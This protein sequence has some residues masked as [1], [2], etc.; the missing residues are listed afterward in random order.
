MVKADRSKNKP[1]KHGVLVIHGGGL[2][3][4]Q[5]NLVGD[6]LSTIAN[7]LIDHFNNDPFLGVEHR[8]A[9]KAKARSDRQLQELD[10]DIFRKDGKRER[11]EHQVM[12]REVLW[13]PPMPKMP[14]STYLSLIW[15]W[16]FA[17]QS[18]N[19]RKAELEKRDQRARGWRCAALKGQ[20]VRPD[21]VYPADWDSDGLE[22]MEQDLKKD[23]H[24]GDFR[25]RIAMAILG[26]AATLLLSAIA[27]ALKPWFGSDLSKFLP[28]IT[29]ILISGSILSSILLGLLAGQEFQNREKRLEHSRLHLTTMILTTAWLSLFLLP[30]LI[31]FYYIDAAVAIA[32]LAG[33]AY[34]LLFLADWATRVLVLLLI[35]LVIWIAGRPTPA[36]VPRAGKRDEI[37]TRLADAR[38]LPRR[39]VQ[40]IGVQVREDRR[41]TA[42]KWLTTLL[43]TCGAPLAVLLISALELL[44]FLPIGGDSLKKMART[45]SDDSY[46]SALKDIHMFLTDSTRAALVRDYIEQTLRD[47]DKEGADSIHIFAHSL[48]TVVAYDT[49]AQIG[50]NNGALITKRMKV[51][52]KIKT[53]LTY[54]CPLNKIRLLASSPAVERDRRSGFDYTRFNT[55]ARLPADLP[56]FVWVNVYALQDFVSD[57]CSSYSNA[58]DRVRP[59]EFSA[60]SA[61]DIVT[62]HGAYWT[63]A[64]FWNTALQALG[65]V[66]ERGAMR[67]IE[68]LSDVNYGGDLLDKLREHGIVTQDQLL[69]KLGSQAER[70]AVAMEIGGAYTEADLR[71]LAERADLARVPAL[72]EEHADLLHDFANVRN[73]DELNATSAADIWNRLS[74]VDAT[75]WHC[76]PS[77]QKD[78]EAW[79]QAASSMASQIS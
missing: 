36:Q 7:G 9:V 69:A 18:H 24:L 30:F 61:N 8:M 3:E 57:V 46:W 43:V 11:L 29:T 35:V 62:A 39:T 45:L 5:K 47:L 67:R 17:F 23:R 21:Q 13:K 63:D 25:A 33:L 71:D 68:K 1:H 26:L 60:W 65:I 2:P 76:K 59:R 44:S 22:Q 55:R 12:M 14:L 52:K 64:G 37:R 19:L 20:P 66:F 6:P 42:A 28:Q 31:L 70:V 73:V 78:V 34:L 74:K 27:E 41:T 53:L 54:G 48:G 50:E 77:S 40:W 72:N 51:Y 16:A 15:D 58:N 49:L 32:A 56:D 38:T 4:D 75:I 79:K 10:I